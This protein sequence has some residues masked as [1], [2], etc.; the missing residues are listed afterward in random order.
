MQTFA[1]PAGVAFFDQRIELDG[2]SY[3]LDFAWCER[4]A[5]W[6]ISIS[7]ADGTLLVAGMAGVSNVRLLHRYKS[8]PRLP[9]GDL[10][11]IDLTS[12][13]AAAGYDD[14][15]T[16]VELYYFTAADLA[17]AGL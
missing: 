17:A 6:L 4:A 9:P 5:S 14:L 11:L 8:D 2:V 3:V 7:A 15:G 1:L 16:N 12:T 13:L 10:A